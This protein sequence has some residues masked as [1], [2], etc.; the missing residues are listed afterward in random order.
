MHTDAFD[1]ILDECLDRLAKGET[2]EQCLARHPEQASRLEPLLRVAHASHDAYRFEPSEDAMR[3]ARARLAAASDGRRA[4][5]HPARTPSLLERLFARPLPVAALASLAVIALTVL[6]VV[7]PSLTPATPASPTA[8]PDTGVPT[9]EPTSPVSPTTPSTPSTPTTP[10]TPTSEPTEPPATEAPG[11]IPAVPAEDGNFVFYLS[12]APNDIADFESLNV[13]IDSIELKP[14]SGPSVSITP[15]GAPVDLAPL[16][17]DIARELWRGEVP[18]GDYKAVLVHISAVEGILA[19]TGASADVV[20][21]SDRLRV[22]IDFSVAGD[23]PVNFVFDV[24]VH[25][26]GNAG[27]GARYILSPQASESGVDRTIQPVQGQVDGPAGETK[28]PKSDPPG[29]AR[30]HAKTEDISSVAA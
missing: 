5:R 10:T 8:G 26:T 6:L 29:Q 1:R 20:L 28:G 11:L 23:E 21:P 16:Q 27:A 15:D 30:G 22:S 12:D 14:E 13:T 2:I 9:T 25:R 3:R 4:A 24:T 17:G 18:A 19:S 7:A